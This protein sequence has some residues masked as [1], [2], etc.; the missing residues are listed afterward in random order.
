VY[1]STL[2][3]ILQQLNASPGIIKID[4]EGAEYIALLGGV[5]YLSSYH[6]LLLVEI[7]P[8]TQLSDLHEMLGNMGYE[9][10]RK[11]RS[12]ISNNLHLVFAHRTVIDL[13]QGQ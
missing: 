1:T 2:G 3:S 9:V 6:P 8:R 11:G 12:K 13:F 10:V 5:G 7:H 4:I